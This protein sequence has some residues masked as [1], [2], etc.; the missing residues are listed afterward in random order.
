MCVCFCGYI[1]SS[2]SAIFVDVD[3]SIDNPELLDVGVISG[4]HPAG[5]LCA[6]SHQ[7]LKLNG[8]SE[9]CRS[10]GHL[11]QQKFRHVVQLE[12]KC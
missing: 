1:P 3:C 5:G 12:P 7:G 6:G 9:L 2:K 10:A 4:Q 8:C 11:V